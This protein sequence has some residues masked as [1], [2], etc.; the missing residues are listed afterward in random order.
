MKVL[1]FDIETA[2]NI[3]Y[4]WGLFKENIPLARLVESSY[5]LCWAAKWIDGDEIMF[6]SVHVSGMRGMLAR[7]HALLDEADVVVHFNGQSFDIPTLNKEFIEQGMPPP[8]PYKQVD[9]MK[10][11]KD[12]FRFTS[13]KMDFIAKF[14]DEGEKKD[15]SFE[16]WVDCMKGDEEAWIK[17]KEYNI[18]DVRILERLYYRFRPWI[19]RHPN[20][21]L[22]S[23]ARTCCPNCGSLDYQKRGFHYTTVG[24]FQRYSC[25]A[26]GNWF[27]DG[28]NV[29]TKT[30]DIMRNV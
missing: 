27:R 19:S 17:M 20:V 5:V 15:T 16:L 10:V 14:L 29:V 2:P 4:V 25:K 1:F 21:A 6:D 24:K 9:L 7:I 26:C 11:A 3:A 12:K 30:K 18:H 13:N 22:Y 23:E 8:S 28:S